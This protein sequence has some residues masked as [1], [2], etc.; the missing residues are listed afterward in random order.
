MRRERYFGGIWWWEW[1]AE[2]IGRGPDSGTFTPE[3]KL[4]TEV[5]E[6]YQGGPPDDPEAKVAGG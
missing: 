6:E 1:S 5:L 3:D 2:R 4:A